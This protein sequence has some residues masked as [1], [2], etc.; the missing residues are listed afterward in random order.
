MQS[1][2]RSEDGDC[3]VDVSAQLVHKLTSRFVECMKVC[4]ECYLPC[5]GFRVA[6]PLHLSGRVLRLGFLLLRLQLETLICV[7]GVL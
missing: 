5:S 1:L 6:P 7:R 4:R 3:T 2:E